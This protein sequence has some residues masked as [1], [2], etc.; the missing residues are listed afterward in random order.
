MFRAIY[1]Y[2]GDKVVN[3]H[4]QFEMSVLFYKHQ[5]VMKTSSALGQKMTNIETM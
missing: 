2:S 5:I 4:M 1:I 3:E